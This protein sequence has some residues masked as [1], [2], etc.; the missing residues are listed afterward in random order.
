MRIDV[1]APTAASI[2]ETV[3]FAR[4][5]EASGAHGVG[6]PDHLEHGRDGFV[7]LALAAKATSSLELYPAVT[8]V[9]TRHPFQIAALARSMQE[10]AGPRFKLVVGAGGSTAERTGQ[11]P[12]SRSRLRETVATLKALL[13]GDSVAFGVGGP[14]RIDDPAP[15]GPPVHL[16]ASGPMAIRLAGEVADGALLFMGISRPIR[17]A[18]TALLAQ[19]L[20]VRGAERSFETT[21]NTLVSVDDEVSVA[22][23]RTRNAAF[24]WLRLGRFDIGL[25]CIGTT[26]DTPG[27]PSALS[28]DL[29]STICDHFFITGTPS[30]CAA[31]L[32]ALANE[33]V[34]RVLLMPTSG[35]QGAERTFSLVEQAALKA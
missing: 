17:G 11:P 8:N 34:G 30:D 21:F 18:G 15:P 24:N 1:L 32:A 4:R 31:K 9:L 25:G 23:E 26:Y 6:F 19:G 10:V 12:A 13:R 3:E 16:A 28:D 5:A 33:G 35:A 29:L 7:A 14:Q 22:R 2:A 20:A 27:S